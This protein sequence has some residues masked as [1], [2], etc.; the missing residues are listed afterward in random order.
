MHPKIT[1]ILEASA[2]SYVVHRHADL[3]VPILSPRDFAQA[4]GYPLER[5]TKTLLLRC[6]QTTTYG[7]TLCSVNKK[8]NMA[9]IAGRLGC[10]RVEL[11][12]SDEL[13]AQLDYP[14]T[15]VSPIGA[16][17]IPV[18]MDAALLELPTIL[19]GAGVVGEEIE[20]S[21]AQLQAITHAL[22]LPIAI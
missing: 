15:G 18:F 9:L 14:S 22:V 16:G 12:N 8:V 3:A 21:P 20:L 6:L 17:S 19:I 7:M 13:L 10:K 11:A 4:L 5:I 1:S 2:A